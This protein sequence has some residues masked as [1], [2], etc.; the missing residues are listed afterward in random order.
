[1]VN[2][3][4]VLTIGPEYRGNLFLYHNAEKSADLFESVVSSKFQ[5][6]LIR[7][8]GQESNANNIIKEISNLSK[9]SSE[10]CNRII[11]Y[12]SGHGNIAGN[13]EYWE[14]LRGNIDQIKIAEL[15]NSLKPLVIV[16]SDSCDS[17][18]MVNAHFINHPYI[19]LG[20]T[21]QGQD[22]MMTGDGGLFTIELT[23][24]INELNIDFTFDD[25]FHKIF[26]DKIEIE[27]F[28]IR[29]SSHDIL[30]EKFFPSI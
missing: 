17:E 16:I 2:K 4:T 15:I 22:A 28:S 11:I 29:F 24:M 20:A 18:H 25:L 23:R 27:T 6:N 1:M 3:I 10:E 21:K 13:K 5:C 9:I 26:D 7:L 19:S 12:Y 8:R 30:D 14:T